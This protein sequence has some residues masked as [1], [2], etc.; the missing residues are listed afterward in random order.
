MIHLDRYTINARVLP[1]L[2]VLAPLAAAVLAW[3]PFTADPWKWGG[4]GLA[5][6][7]AAYFVS[8]VTRDAGKVLEERLWREWG[9][10]PSATYL[11][12]SDPQLGPKE[13][14]ELHRTLMRLNSEIVLPS[15]EEEA[16]NPTAA[17]Q[18]YNRAAAWLRNRTRDTKKFALLFSENVAYG[19]RRNLLAIRAWG[20]AS[21]AFC[22][23]SAGLATWMGKPA[24][25]HLALGIAIGL[26][27]LLM[28]PA[29]LRRQSDVYTLRLIE[30]VDILASEGG[31]PKPR[32]RAA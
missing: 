10:C 27:T 9:G 14:Q 26:Y 20:V 3:I 7:V 8:Q 12:H 22:V 29:G 13:K 19:F 23:G 6:S 32:K 21:S 15:P 5:T 17:D 31:K 16:R 4:V 25:L 2:I 24:L 28:T 18:R 1:A 11:R 30:T